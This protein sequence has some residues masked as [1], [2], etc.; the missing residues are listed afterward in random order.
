MSY[1][2]IRKVKADSHFKDFVGSIW[3]RKNESDE[4]A[5]VCAK[6]RNSVQEPRRGFVSAK[7]CS[8][9]AVGFTKRIYC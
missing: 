5:A 2:D 1:P 3:I 7:I 4:S 6:K 8:D 9:V